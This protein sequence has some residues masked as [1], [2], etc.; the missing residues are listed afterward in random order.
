MPQGEDTVLVALR[1]LLKGN[2]DP[3][4]E[5][6][7]LDLKEP[8]SPILHPPKPANIRECQTPARLARARELGPLLKERGKV[9]SKSGGRLLWRM[10]GGR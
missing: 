5:F 3:T 6:D 1:S 2:S 4:Q 8:S 9:I 10:D 7:K